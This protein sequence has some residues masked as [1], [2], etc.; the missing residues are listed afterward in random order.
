MS[1]TSGEIC[2]ST[3]QKDWRP[4]YGLSHLLLTIKSLLLTP[5]AESAL[6]EA[7]GKLLLA[8]YGEFCRHAALLTSIHCGRRAKRACDESEN[9]DEAANAEAGPTAPP[10]EA[11]PSGGA[12][13]GGAAR[14]KLR[15]V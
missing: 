12:Q 15:R 11:A 4:D 7:A 13:V 14:R 2:V 9:R 8:D 5:N 1:P 3:L 6:N 10:A